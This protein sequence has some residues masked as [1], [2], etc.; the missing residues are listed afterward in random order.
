MIWLL[1]SHERLDL[2]GETPC[3]AA[4]TTLDDPSQISDVRLCRGGWK[5]R[6][7]VAGS[8]ADSKRLLTTL[9]ETTSAKVLV[10]C[11]GRWLLLR[12]AEVET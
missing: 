6:W 8:L 12:R 9:A 3:V 1:G 7:Y 11:G 2:P 5:V 4:P 10:G